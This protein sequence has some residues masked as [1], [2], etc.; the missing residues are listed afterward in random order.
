MRKAVRHIV[1]LVDAQVARFGQGRRKDALQAQAAIGRRPA[2]R[3]C[4]TE[5][6]CQAWL[7]AQRRISLGAFQCKQEAL[8][9]RQAHR[10]EEDTSRTEKTIVASSS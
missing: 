1:G 10:D 6:A 8:I 2:E 9:C 5:S 7:I 4:C 3:P